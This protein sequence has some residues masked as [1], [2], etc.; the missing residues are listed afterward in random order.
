MQ[1]FNENKLLPVTYKVL[2]TTQ[3][4]YLHNVISF[5]PVSR[6]HSSSV[7]TLARLNALL[8]YKSLIIPFGMQH[9]MILVG[10]CF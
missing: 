7:V 9:L 1:L 10:I 3:T 8:H 2:T 4:T 6:T 5:Q